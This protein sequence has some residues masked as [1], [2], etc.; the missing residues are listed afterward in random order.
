M[1]RFTQPLHSGCPI[2]ATVK[3]VAVHGIFL[4]TINVFVHDHEYSIILVA[5]N[6]P[7][8]LPFKQHQAVWLEKGLQTKDVARK[9]CKEHIP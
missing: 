7:S 3:I 5:V 2:D 9:Y 8:S 1:Q 6:T 4:E